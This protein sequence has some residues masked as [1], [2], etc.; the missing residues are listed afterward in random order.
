MLYHL[1]FPLSDQFAA[2]N[3]FRYIT[4]RAASAVVTA[5]LLS[6]LLGPAF[7]RML[8]RLS[9]GAGPLRFPDDPQFFQRPFGKLVAL[10]IITRMK[11]RLVFRSGYI[12]RQRDRRIILMIKSDLSTSRRGDG[13]FLAAWARN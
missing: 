6:M 7:I 10:P 2:F 13:F 8:R 5:L 9:I 3:V 4:F 12:L 11:D 1:L